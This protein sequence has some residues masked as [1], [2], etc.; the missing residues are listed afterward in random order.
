MPPPKRQSVR[1]RDLL[2]AL[3][4]RRTVVGAFALPARAATVAL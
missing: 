3:A 1:R 2:A 4:A